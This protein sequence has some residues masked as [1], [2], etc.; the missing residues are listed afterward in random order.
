M[1]SLWL[2]MAL[3]VASPVGA[4]DPVPVRIHVDPPSVELSGARDRQ[5]M[6]VQAELPDGSAR[7]VTS[8]AA[9]TFDQPVATVT[10]AFVAPVADGR[11]ALTVKYAGQAVTVPVVVTRAAVPDPLRF[12]NDVLPEIGR[13]H[14]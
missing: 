10:N 8:A 1:R 14:V 12:R 11:A 6:V 13:A 3:F 4:A 7:D 2:G 9:M 5:G